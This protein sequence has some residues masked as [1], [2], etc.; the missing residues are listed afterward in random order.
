MTCKKQTKK[1]HKSVLLINRLGFSLK[2]YNYVFSLHINSCNLNTRMS[3]YIQTTAG[4]MATCIITVELQV[5]H[6]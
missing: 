1:Q 6:L 5:D 4:N 3:D 2:Y